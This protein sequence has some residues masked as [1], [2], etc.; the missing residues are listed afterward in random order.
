AKQ[1]AKRAE[2][3]LETL[4]MVMHITYGSPARMTE[5]STWLLTNSVH[6][7]RSI[8]CHAR[9]LLF[10]GMYN[11]STSMT[12]HERIIAHVIPQEVEVL[13]I[14]YLVYIRPLARY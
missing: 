9:G 12:G 3:L 1:Y 13:F 4:F 2:Q 10:L 14:Q 11:K 8:Y 5:I 7:T 6:R